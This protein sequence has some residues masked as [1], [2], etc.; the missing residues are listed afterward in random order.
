MSCT[1]FI[2]D[3]HLDTAR[4][5]TSRAFFRFLKDIDSC[6][7]LYILGDLFEAWPGDDDDSTL[8]REV[9]E[10]LSSFN[11]ADAR[12]YIMHGN[13]DFLLGNDFCSRSG[14]QLLPEPT[15]I[16]LYGDSALIMHGD[17]LCTDDSDY[18]AFRSMVRDP[19]WQ[20]EV[21]ALP[22]TE[23]KAMARKFREQS[24]E[25]KTNKAEDIVDVSPQA[26]DAAMEEAGIERLIHGHT[27]RAGCFATGF[28]H[29]WVLGDWEYN[30]RVLKVTSQEWTLENI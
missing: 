4:P 12:T 9:R 23:R 19:G 8:A 10:A 26:V 24:H 2:S 7:S 5:S 6:E 1:Y 3:L 16:D 15:L 30:P 18:L 29:R 14:C 13:R 22:L 20:A 21:L 28:G 27:H 17:V 25:A 11:A